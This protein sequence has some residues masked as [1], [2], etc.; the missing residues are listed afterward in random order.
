ME[1]GNY[2]LEYFL[3]LENIFKVIRVDYIRSIE[4]GGA[5]NSGIRLALPF[6]R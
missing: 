4:K 6:A 5:N 2:Y 1:S 3:G